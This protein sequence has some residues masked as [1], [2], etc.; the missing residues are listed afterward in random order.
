MHEHNFVSRFILIVGQNLSVSQQNIGHTSHLSFQLTVAVDANLVG[1]KYVAG[2]S[3]FNPS[4]A[5]MHVAKAL[6]EKH[7]KVHMI[8]DNCTKRHPSKR[9]SC[10]RISKQ[11]RAKIMAKILRS[12]LQ[13]QQ[14]LP[15]SFEKRRAVQ[16]IQRNF[17]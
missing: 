6:S 14:S 7:V 13:T 10:K 5:V 2:K 3:T 17:H 9:F 4:S 1:Y 15:E 8:A 11:E 16:A 12:Q